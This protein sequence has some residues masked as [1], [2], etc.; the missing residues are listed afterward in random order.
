M[1]GRVNK[2]SATLKYGL[3]CILIALVVATGHAQVNFQVLGQY[4]GFSFQSVTVRDNYAYATGEGFLLSTYNILDQQPTG[5]RV[6]APSPDMFGYQVVVAGNYAYV[7]TARKGLPGGS[8]KILDVSDPASPRVVGSYGNTSYDGLIVNGNLGYVGSGT[9]LQVLNLSNPASPQLVRTVSLTGSLAGDGGTVVGNRLYLCEGPSGLSVWD[10]SQPDN[11]QRLGILG[12]LGVVRSVHVSGNYAFVAAGQWLGGISGGLRV[13]D[14]SNP[15]NMSVVAEVREG[16]NPTFPLVRVDNYLYMPI[17]DFSGYSIV[18]DISNPT[19]PGIRGSLDGMV[20]GANVGA[21]QLVSYRT[22]R[23]QVWDMTNR[24]N[25]TLVRIFAERAPQALAYGSGFVFTAEEGQFAVYDVTNPAAITSAAVLPLPNDPS[26]DPRVRVQSGLAAVSYSIGRGKEVTLVDVSNPR[27]PSILSHYTPNTN[28]WGITLQNNWLVVAHNGGFDVVDISNRLAPVRVYRKASSWSDRPAGVAITGDLLLSADYDRVLRVYDFSNP[29]APVLRGQV[30]VAS[31]SYVA[32]VDASGG[33]AIVVLSSGDAVVVDISDPSQPRVVANWDNPRAAMASPRVRISGNMAYVSD[34]Q[35]LTAFD[36]SRLPA[37]APV[38]VWEGPAREAVASGDIVYVA[39]G[40]GGLYTMRRGLPEGSSDLQVRSLRFSPSTSEDLMEGVT[41][42]VEAEVFNAGPAATVSP[43]VRFTLGNQSVDASV[44]RLS[45]GSGES[46]VAVSWL[47]AHAGSGRSLRATV[48]PEQQINDPIRTNNTISVPFPDLDLPDLAVTSVQI[49]PQGSLTQG[50]EFSV[51]A[52]IRN[53]GGGIARPF[54][55]LMEYAGR[56]ALSTIDGLRAGA[57]TAVSATFTAV[58]GQTQV[59]VKVDADNSIQESTKDNNEVVQS[60]PPIVA[61]D[62]EIVDLTFAPAQPDEGDTV[63][64]TARVRNNGAPLKGNF[65]VAFYVDDRLIYNEPSPLPNLGTGEEMEVSQHFTVTSEVRQL[66]AVVDPAN[67]IF[68]TDEDNNTRT[69]PVPQPPAPDLEV[70]SLTFTQPM[71]AGTWQTA[72]AEIANN[73]GT[74]RNVKV[75]FLVNGTPIR[76]E[77]VARISRSAPVTVQASWMV[78]AGTREVKVVVDPNEQTADP[79]RSNNVRSERVDVPTADVAVESVQLP[80]ADTELIVGE[81]PLTG[82]IPVRVSVLNNSDVGSGSIDIGIFADGSYVAGRTI[83]VAGREQQQ[84]EVYVPLRD[85]IGKSQLR[86]VADVNNVLLEPNK[87]DNE[88]TVPIPRWRLPDLEVVDVTWTPQEFRVGQTVYFNVTVRNRGEGRYGIVAWGGQQQQIPVSLSIGSEMVATKQLVGVLQPGASQTVQIPWV[89]YPIDNPE[90]TVTVDSQDWLPE[91]DENNNTLRKPM[92]VRLS[93]PDFA[94]TDVQVSPTTGLNVGDPVTIRASV[95]SVS[96]AYDG[97]ADLQVY[98]YVDGNNIGSQTVSLRSGEEKQIEFTWRALPGAAHDVRITLAKHVWEVNEQNNTLQITVPMQTQPVDLVVEQIS[99]SLPSQLVEGDTVTTHVRVRNAG[100]GDVRLPFDVVLLVNGGWVGQQRVDNLAAGES[101]DLTFTWNAYRTEKLTIRAVVDAAG[102]V[103]E[104]DETN[105]SLSREI[106][107][108]VVARSEVQTQ[109]QPLGLRAAAGA[110]VSYQIT[111]NNYTNQ[112]RTVRPQVMGLDGLQVSLQPAAVTLQ[113]WASSQHVLQ[114]Q[115]PADASVGVHEFTLRLTNEDDTVVTERSVSLEITR[116]PQIADLLPANGTRTG[117]TSVVFTWRTDVFSSSEVFLRAEDETTYRSF[118]GSDGT[119]H[120]VRVDGLQRGKTYRFYVVSRTPQGTAQSEERR[121]SVT[122]AVAFAQR[123]YRFTVDKDFDQRVRLQVRNLSSSPQTARVELVNPYEDVPA[124]FIGA[125]GDTPV[126]LQANDTQEVTLALHFQNATRNRYTFIARLHSGEGADTSVDE[127]PVQVAVDDTVDIEVQDLGT[128]PVTLQKTIR[129]VNRRNK[130]VAGLTLQLSE[131]LRGQVAMDKELQGFRLEPYESITVRIQP[132][133]AIQISRYP[134]IQ[135]RLAPGRAVL[136]DIP[137]ARQQL[138][139]QRQGSVLVVDKMNRVQAELH[140]VDFTPPA[141]KQLYAVRLDNRILEYLNQAASCSNQG[142]INIPFSVQ[143]NEPGDPFLL[144]DMR[145]A[146]GWSYDQIAPQSAYFYVNGYLVGKLENT[147]P[148]G[149][150][151]FDVPAEY[152][153]LGDFPTVNTVTMTWSLPN[154]GHFL[155]V[156]NVKLVIF[157]KRMVQYVAAESEDEALRI[158]QNQPFFERHDD[159][160]LD[161]LATF[162]MNSKT[163]EKGIPWRNPRMIHVPV[164]AG[165]LTDAADSPYC[166][167]GKG[168]PF[169]D[170]ACGGYQGRILNEGFIYYLENQPGLRDC[171]LDENGRPKILFYPIQGFGGMHQAVLAVDRSELERL[172][173]KHPFKTRPDGRPGGLLGGIQG[174]VIDPWYTQDM[175]IYDAQKWFLWNAGAF[176]DLY[177]NNWDMERGRPPVWKPPQERTR[178]D[179]GGNQGN[180]YL[181]EPYHFMAVA[182]GRVGFLL[183]DEQGHRAGFIGL[184]EFVNDYGAYANIVYV[185]FDDGK[186]ISFAG[187]LGRTP[188][189]YTIRLVPMHPEETKTDLVVAW[190]GTDGEYHLVEY[191]DVNVTSFGRQGGGQATLQIDQA[192][193]VPTL[194]DANGNTVY[195]DTTSQQALA[196]SSS[197]I[198]QTRSVLLPAGL[199]LVALPVVNEETPMA[200]LLEQGQAARWNPDKP[201]ANKY[202]AF[203]YPYASTARRG[204]GYWMKLNRSTPVTVT[205]PTVELQPYVITLRAGWNMIG[206]PYT[207]PVQWDINAI[208]VRKDNMELSLAQAETQGWVEGY[209]WRWDGSTYRLVYSAGVPLPNVDEALPA[210]S[211]A[212]VFAYQPC[213]LILPV[214]QGV[215][216]EMTRKHSAVPTGAWSLSLQVRLNGS[217]SETII[218]YLP[219]GRGLSVGIPPLPPGA[220]EGVQIMAVHN[221]QPLAAELRSG[222][223]EVWDIEVHVPPGGG[224]ERATLWWQNV[225]RAPRGVNPVLV[226]LQTGERKFL[227]HTSSHT[228][229]VSRQ[230]GVYRFRVELLPM[231]DLLR[232]TGVRVSGGRSQGTYTVAFNVNAGAQVEVTVLSAGRPVRKLMQTVTRSAGVQQVSWDGRD[233]GGVALPA[234]AYMVEVKAI[235]ADGQVA[236]VSVPIVLTR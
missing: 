136:L 113:P 46:A 145:P 104:S 42:R 1:L 158:A 122:E 125:G 133:F 35:S 8:I 127:V 167:M 87:R 121:L 98:A 188:R 32:D 63:R 49:Q 9:Q 76:T 48:D 218:G 68:E 66:R 117:N 194:Q 31:S 24:T 227:R 72:R 156:A 58:S 79:Q 123:E 115:V 201:G 99:D 216:A 161:K 155:Q 220:R 162:L 96:G 207:E 85:L 135:S 184:G 81:Y 80:S 171:L 94:V 116:E 16:D 11:P 90:I 159:P 137:E 38:A 141:G 196:T 154:G 181:T 15:A 75:Q 2:I 202:E 88:K 64:V 229:A 126:N 191:R 177:R 204:A 128:D 108:R 83:S 152:L 54:R 175:K 170:Y 20:G 59:R 178:Q 29:A 215:A 197:D 78:R 93:A 153:K 189:N 151:T 73:G 213:D 60:I 107:T 211:G 163:D 195:P 25:P 37:F 221:G 13:V 150:Y 139:R 231:G 132:T 187:M 86:V 144:V 147:V 41:L 173:V 44:R 19:S 30:S 26:N 33:V 103:P 212:W 65:V 203:P 149:L 52:L 183:S 10:I 208:R 45:L 55:V 28:V 110:T 172:R 224:E 114:V 157:A 169:A 118:T 102:N 6:S 200:G 112:S 222:T 199:Q 235:G 106:S 225:H 17:M 61:P 176:S 210:W 105:N 27:A 12:N 138:R 214:P 3:L 223:R 236:R 47:V 77:T 34:G 226:D 84:I 193:H 39:A 71:E 185:E 82:Q 91:S 62:L 179:F 186:R 5:G 40:A 131:S 182:T 206:N 69:V 21:N 57:Q 146:K 233:A 56:T 168:S 18:I 234:G 7:L 129:I 100:S 230:G 174:K 143:P 53:S 14:V 51:R 192:G 92:P 4:P 95:A 120:Q 217:T 36:L 166:L 148:N 160:C 70:R 198:S 23:L 190:L 140:N 111:L 164:L 205:V 165:I 180:P 219:T 74:A 142:R 209:A 134:E 22:S 97:L 228:F 232:I 124:G 43:V 109:I 50:D 89:V 101:R 130:P 119:D 67:Q